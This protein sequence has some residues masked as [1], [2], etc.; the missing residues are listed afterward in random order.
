MIN[1]LKKAKKA[2]VAELTE[3]MGS[4]EMVFQ[5]TKYTTTLAKPSTMS[6]KEKDVIWELFRLNMETLYKTTGV[7]PWN[8]TKKRA[9][10]FHRDSRFVTIIPKGGQLESNLLGYCMFRF[11]TEE[12]LEEEKELVVYCYELQVAKEAQGHGFG[13]HLMDILEK[14]GEKWQMQKIMLTVLL[15]NKDAHKFYNK[16]GF[17]RD[18]ISPEDEQYVILSKPIS[19]Q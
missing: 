13:R 1:P 9:E 15:A 18:P 14:L 11:D 7:F 16:I 8:P 2:S 5:D 6:S 19:I 10:L 17:T 3:A 12:N 4:N